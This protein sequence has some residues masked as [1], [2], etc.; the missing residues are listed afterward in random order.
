MSIENLAQ[1]ITDFEKR[2]FPESTEQ[3]AGV[4]TEFVRIFEN[5]LFV[6]KNLTDTEKK[7]KSLL[8]LLT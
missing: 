2:E 5:E 3:T 7:T 4:I 6:K 8:E 1:I